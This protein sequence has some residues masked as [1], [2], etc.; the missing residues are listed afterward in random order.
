MALPGVR[1]T[2]GQREHA[3]DQTAVPKHHNQGQ[4]H[5]RNMPPYNATHKQKGG[6]TINQSTGPNMP[7][8]ATTKPQPN[9][10]QK[11]YKRKNAV[12]NLPIKIKQRYAQ[13]KKGTDVV[14]Q[15]FPTAMNKDRKST[16]LNSSHVRISYA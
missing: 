12:R 3:P 8:L 5:Q 10:G 1:K 6:Q 11:V 15:M 9:A 16:R 13:Y 2:W 7:Y 14:A 4:R